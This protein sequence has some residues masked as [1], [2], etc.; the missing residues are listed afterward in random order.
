MVLPP[1]PPHP[2]PTL[3]APMVKNNFEGEAQIVNNH[4]EF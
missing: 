4:G 2:P 1:P 3:Q